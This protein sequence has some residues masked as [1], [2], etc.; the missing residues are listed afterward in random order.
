VL[1]E[2][3]NAAIDGTAEKDKVTHIV[4]DAHIVP[5]AQ[6]DKQT[7]TSTEAIDKMD[8]YLETS[9][10]PSSSLGDSNSLQSTPTI[11]WSRELSILNSMGFYDQ[12][13]LVP[14]LQ[15][16]CKQVETEAEVDHQGL[17]RVVGSLLTDLA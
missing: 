17:Q 16:H 7:I 8:K 1:T 9:P 3:G 6:M 14:L 4:G 2:V 12:E 13:K 10:G 15:S 5:C 11:Q